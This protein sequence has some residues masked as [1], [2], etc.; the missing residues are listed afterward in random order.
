MSDWQRLFSE[1]RRV[2]GHVSQ[3]LLDSERLLDSHGYVGAHARNKA[4]QI[5]SGRSG[6]VND[7]DKW[8]P[9]WVARFFRFKGNNNKIQKNPLVFINCILADG[10]NRDY[11]LPA[12]KNPV[13]VAGVIVFEGNDTAASHDDYLYEY[14][15]CW[16]REPEKC[17]NRWQA[18][19]PVS[20]PKNMNIAS[21]KTYGVSLMEIKDRAD[22]LEKVITPLIEMTNLSSPHIENVIT[23]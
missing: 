2:Y 10:G 7:P 21:M 14:A 20:I 9:H 3:I 22:L 12:D 6:S 13:I 23:D 1:L 11:S 5:G 18:V 15:K 19:S 17:L 4:S 16:L 8:A